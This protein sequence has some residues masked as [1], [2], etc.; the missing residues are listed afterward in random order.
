M[1]IKWN[2]GTKLAIWIIAFILFILSFVYISFNYDVGLVE[3]DY[4][5]KGLVYQQRI[6]AIANAQK[7]NADF[8]I[9]QNIES[10]VI[11]TP[12]IV[13]D[14]GTITFFRPSDNDLDRVYDL[15]INDLHEIIIPKSEFVLGKY[16]IKFNWKHLQNEYYVEKTFYIK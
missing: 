7:I 3:K 13:V 12:D 16:K 10:V 14:S 1:K 4:Y 8:E 9:N 15:I 2:W 11:K 5:P 6:D